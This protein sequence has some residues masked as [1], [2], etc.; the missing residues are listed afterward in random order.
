M[1]TILSGNNSKLI[2]EAFKRRSWWVEVPNC[3]SHFNFKWA[4]V[5]SKIK[6]RDLTIQLD[7]NYKQIVNHVEGHKEISTKS[8]LLE[9]LKIY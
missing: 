3:N 6:F 4:P 8:R 9:N 2:R 1:Y 5:S 7:K